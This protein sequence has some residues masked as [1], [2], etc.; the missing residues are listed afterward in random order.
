[1][2]EMLRKM[3]FPI[4]IIVLV[5]FVAMIVFQWGMEM[6]SRRNLSM[7][8]AAGAV[9]GEEIPWQDYNRVYNNMTAAEQA[10]NKGDEEADLPDAKLAEIQENAWNQ[11]VA[12]RL[13]TQEADKHNIVV[14]DEEIY[15][16]LRMAPP[17]ELQKLPYFQTDGKFD[18]QKYVTAMANP[19]MAGYWASLEPLVQSDLRKAKLREMIVQAVDVTEGE[20]RSYWE[21]SVERVKVGMINVDY[22]RFSRP[23]P[24]ISD[25]QAK[26]YYDSHKDSYPVPERASINVVSLEK[27]P[28]RY[29]WE[30]SYNR[31]KQLYD[32]LRAGANF[33][34]LAVAL[35]EDQVSARDSGN[36]GWFA[37]GRMVEEFDHW[38]F[39]AKEG[40]LSEPL[41]TQYGWH[42]I[43]HHGFR[44]QEQ[45]VRGEKKVVKEANCS[46]ILIKAHASQETLDGLHEKLVE[47]HDLAKEKGFFP[48]AE[49][50]SLPVQPSGLFKRDDAVPVIGKNQA[51]TDF[52]FNE[53]VQ[54]LGEVMENQSAFFVCE[55]ASHQPAGTAEFEE[56]K[57]KARM[58]VQKQVVAGYCRDTANAIWADIQH[59]TPLKEAAQMHGEE[60]EEPTEFGRDS[61][62][63]GLGRAPE[64]IGAAFSLTSP[65]Q[66]AP[67]TEFDQGCVIFQLLQRT[68]PDISE[69]SAKR[70]S[71]RTS[72]LQAKQNEMFAGWYQSLM[73]SSEIVNNTQRMAEN[74]DLY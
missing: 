67:P 15:A 25:D 23:P 32:S 70:D 9:N 73:K 19:E 22:G 68:Q 74:P 52:A 51:V 57:E 41:R 39:S 53:K 55:V 56:I 33:K 16:Y 36:L 49:Q 3:I 30:E 7:A 64:A 31:A 11:L 54:T 48:A 42:I 20:V 35:S 24:K 21:E 62:V 34:E 50:L 59:G 71:I 37:Q 6:S 13:L 38:V 12:D 72:I 29:D 10:K 58:D 44:E 60:Y 8:N 63:R 2:F 45:Q 69:F 26:A 28:G 27:K 5:L 66:L 61:Y 47:F 65:G 17:T 14:T 46:H 18:Y 40:D 1:M 43:Q 4:I